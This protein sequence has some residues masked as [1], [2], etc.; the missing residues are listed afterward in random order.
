MFVFRSVQN[1]DVL[2]AASMDGF[3]AVRKTNALPAPPTPRLYLASAARASSRARSKT[4][5]LCVAAQPG[6]TRY[7][8]YFRVRSWNIWEA[9]HTAKAHKLL[10]CAIHVGIHTMLKSNWFNASAV[11]ATR[12]FALIS[13]CVSSHVIVGKVRPP[14][15][16][17][18]VQ[19]YLHPPAGKYEEVALLDSS[20]RNS[21][22]FTA[23]GK[24]N[25]V[26]ERLKEEAAKLGANGIL[27]NGVSDQ[28]ASSVGTGV[29]TATA[30][31]NSATG[32]GFGSSGT[33]FVKSGNGLAIY[34]E[35]DPVATH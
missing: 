14:I 11:A 19:I 3:T 7:F 17:D 27:L 31:G 10:K 34:V 28:A 5:S 9:R 32:F 6:P 12:A 30:H 20:S 21:F 33:V 25:K 22:S 23:Q 35:P 15:S 18:Q 26:I 1:R 29:G 2:P 16:P 24:T 8:P 13:G 4:G